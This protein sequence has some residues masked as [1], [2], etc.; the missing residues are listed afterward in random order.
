MSVALAITTTLRLAAQLLM[1]QW[2][3]FVESFAL[4]AIH[5]LEDQRHITHSPRP[6]RRRIHPPQ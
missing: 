2:H 1:Y 5:P 4:P 6:S 3:E